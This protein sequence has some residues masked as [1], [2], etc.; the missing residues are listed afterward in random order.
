MI[1]LDDVSKAFHGLPVFSGLSLTVPEQAVMG[2]V[3][4]SGA[5]K[6]TLLRLIARLL[7]P[8]SGAVTIAA[9]R[10]SYVFQEPR[11]L[12][13]RSAVDNIAAAVQAAGTDR[14]SALH[15]AHTWLARVGLA[16][17]AGYYPAQLS[18]GMRQ[19]VA[20][21]RAF[22]V[23]PQ[24]LLLDEPFSHL[25]DGHK[26]ELMNRL[27]ELIAEQAVTVVYVTHDLRELDGL[28][29]STLRLKTLM[30]PALV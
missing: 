7:E 12:P 8:D 2:I 16:D 28:A 11:L 15:T 21:A 10:L 25:D 1:R 6:T 26:Q 14:R 24:V 4:P 22:A 19:R 5:G 29:D 17:F 27:R 30:K 18:G 23:Q 13:W 3:G 20:L 9:S